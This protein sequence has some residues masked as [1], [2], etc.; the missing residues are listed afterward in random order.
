MSIARIW[1][2]FFMVQDRGASQAL[3][4]RSSVGIY[5]AEVFSGG[6][7]IV[8][9]E[10]SWNPLWNHPANIIINVLMVMLDRG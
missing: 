5:V 6:C 4:P 3:P 2:D 9:E 7:W 1:I 10:G 8:A